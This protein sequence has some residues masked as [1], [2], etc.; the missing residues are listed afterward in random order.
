MRILYG[1]YIVHYTLVANHQL[2]HRFVMP[3]G[4]WEHTVPA[5]DL[6]HSAAQALERTCAQ[7]AEVVDDVGDRVAGIA[8]RV[9]GPLS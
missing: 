4:P 6:H 3:I 2:R 7:F 9:H 1:I 8:K 5:A